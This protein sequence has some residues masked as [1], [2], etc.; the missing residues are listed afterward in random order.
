MT[1]NSGFSDTNSVTMHGTNTVDTTAKV[2]TSAT[3]QIAIL[4]SICYGINIYT[5]LSLAYNPLQEQSCKGSPAL[6]IR[7]V[8]V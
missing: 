8:Q 4:A 6:L 1:K 2:H 7:E 3:R 5:H